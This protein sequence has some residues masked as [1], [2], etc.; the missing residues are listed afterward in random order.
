LAELGFRVTVNTDNRLM[1][2]TT[3]TREFVLLAEAFDYSLTDMRWLTL[4]AM[5]SAFHAH[6]ERLRLI[7]QVIKPG[8]QQLISET[9]A[10]R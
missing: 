8:Y 1:S 3:L 10:A 5:K 6:P 4:N 2:N 9:A 7:E